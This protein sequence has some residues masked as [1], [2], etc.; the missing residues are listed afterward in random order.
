VPREAR[1]ARC[2]IVAG[3]LALVAKVVTPVMPVR[4][5]GSELTIEEDAKPDR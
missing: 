3:V 1:T 5:V 4:R 2:R